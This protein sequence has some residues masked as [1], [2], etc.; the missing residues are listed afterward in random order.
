MPIPTLDKPGFALVVLLTATSGQLLPQNRAA[1]QGRQPFQLLADSIARLEAR[2]AA[3]GQDTAAAPLLLMLGH[4]KQQAEAWMVIGGSSQ[5]SVAVPYARGRPQEYER[6]DVHA[7]FVYNGIH[8]AQLAGSFPESPLVV[9]AAWATVNRTET[10]ECGDDIGCEVNAS[11][12]EYLSFASFASRYP[13]SGYVDSAMSVAEVRLAQIVK[14]V[15]GSGLPAEAFNP[16]VIGRKLDK[17]AFAAGRMRPAAR[18]SL[19]AVIE[20]FRSGM[21]GRTG[22]GCGPRLGTP[23]PGDTVRVDEK[24][25]EA[26]EPIVVPVTTESPRY[27][28]GAIWRVFSAGDTTMIRCL[29]SG[30]FL[31][32]ALG[33]CEPMVLTS[34]LQLP[35]GLSDSVIARA[36]LD[37]V[38]STVAADAAADSGWSVPAVIGLLAG[39][40]GQPAGVRLD[41]FT[42]SYGQRFKRQVVVLAGIPN[43]SSAL[44]ERQYIVTLPAALGLR[45]NALLTDRA[46]QFFFHPEAIGG[47][48]RPAQ[49]LQHGDSVEWD[50]EVYECGDIAC[51][52]VADTIGR[53]VLKLPQARAEL[54][55]WPDHGSGVAVLRVPFFTGSDVRN[56]FYDRRLVSPSP[57]A[58]FFDSLGLITSDSLT[59]KA[60]IRWNGKRAIL[61]AR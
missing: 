20:H 8:W 22:T 30:F 53:R 36:V 50:T 28:T 54:Y 58:T 24:A 59:A 23:A 57:Q 11:V 18:D 32:R 5:D 40:S 9:K 14:R 37:H 51:I 48:N 10:V 55:F 52:V 38:D 31:R 35:P 43:D 33:S 25:L 6:D 29:A 56:A 44:R 19:R 49:F 61:Q 34:W 13:Q 12:N 26:V 27:S 4:L 15:V 45:G 17:L 41:C 46:G 42:T 39:R 2:I 47:P 7:K 21:A 16:R 60:L 3:A 1:R